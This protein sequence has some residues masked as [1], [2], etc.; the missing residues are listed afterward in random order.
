MSFYRP[1]RHSI[2]TS[3]NW[4]FRLGTDD[5]LLLMK[6]PKRPVTTCSYAM[7][8]CSIE[9]HFLFIPLRSNESQ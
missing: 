6:E 5:V 8:N 1:I 7:S 4:T 9:A 2:G 3:C